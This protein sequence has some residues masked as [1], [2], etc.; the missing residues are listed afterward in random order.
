VAA[1]RVTSP[2]GREWTVSVRRVRL[3]KWAH[4][5]YDPADDAAG[6]LVFGLFAYIVLAPLFW[7]V[8]PLARALIELPVALARPLVSSTRWVEAECGWPSAIRIVWRTSRRRAAS[9]ADH[10]AT[11]LAEGYDDLT[12]EGAERE[13]MTRPPGLDDLDA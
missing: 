1:R 11:Q 2:D 4:S 12:P 5:E 10:V 13:A 7:F 9:V 3:P 8:V 6:D